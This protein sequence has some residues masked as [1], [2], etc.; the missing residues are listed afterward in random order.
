MRISHQKGQWSLRFAMFCLHFFQIS[1]W[2]RLRDTGRRPTR[3]YT[4]LH[5][6]TEISQVCEL[7]SSVGW[8][9][10]NASSIHHDL[11]WFTVIHLS[12][13]S[14]AVELMLRQGLYSVVNIVWL[15][16]ISFDKKPRNKKRAP[17][18]WRPVWRPGKR[19]TS[20]AS[21]ERLRVGRRM[22]LYI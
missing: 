14:K 16:W 13:R 11:P 12:P 6:S 4:V 8:N 9:A 10:S 18:A 15:S 19:C 21:V 1:M 3:F 5:G 17:P 2:H 22:R 20:S 7:L